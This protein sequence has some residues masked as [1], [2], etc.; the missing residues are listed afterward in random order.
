MTLLVLAAPIAVWTWSNHVA[1]QGLLKRFK[2]Q[3]LPTTPAELNRWYAPV[4]P[5]DNMALPLID[6]AGAVRS[7][8]SKG[9]S[10][11]PYFSGRIPWPGTTNTLPGPPHPVP[12]EEL[13][14][15]R[16]VV[17]GT[18]EAWAALE[19]ARGRR[20][21]RY[22]IDLRSGF[23]TTLPHLAQTKLLAQACALRALVA[24]ED[25][26]PQEAALAIEDG[27]LIHES[28][29]PEPLWISQ[30]VGMASL[31]ITL[32]GVTDVLSAGP[33]PVDSLERLQRR[34]E[35]FA[36]T[37]RFAGAMAGEL[38]C[39]MEGFHGSPMDQARAWGFGVGPGFGPGAPA[40][41]QLIHAT[42]MAVYSALGLNAADERFCL[43]T[44]GQAID[45][46]RL[47]WPKART[48]AP[49]IT[50]LLGETEGLAG[51]LK[52][53]FKSRMFLPSL[54][55]ALTRDGVHLAKLR[56][57]AAMLAIERFR[58]SHEGRVP[59]RLDD[60]VPAYLS[61]VP[62]DPFDGKPI[63][64][65]RSPEGYTLHSVGTDLRDDDART[66]PRAKYSAAAEL[67]V[68]LRVRRR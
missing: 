50:A 57:G 47:P 26:K 7:P 24:I 43:T 4:A 65:Q 60:L 21:S 6:A 35:S 45:A 46:S 11:F 48:A 34:L 40:G 33:L 20:L 8:V 66:R 18:P 55:N 13:A 63:R 41:P 53:R 2:A 36:T 31:S 58:A 14:R 67:D 17:E 52:G 9:S 28:L 37:N 32:D 59:D 64:Y 12:P 10:N 3:G 25:G 22:P 15:W 51:V 38:S 30:L 61:A 39:M 27:L 16:K 19:R 68:V 29:L 23:L 56:L 44:L 5:Q 49:P 62:E 1:S 54:D 42:L